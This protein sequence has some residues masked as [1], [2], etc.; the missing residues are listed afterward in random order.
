MAQAL[1]E[2]GAKSIALL[3]IREDLGNSTAAE[4]HKTTGLPIQFYAVDVTD[5]HSVAEAVSRAHK[6]LGAIDIV[7]NSAGIAE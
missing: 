3:D 6:D 7:V 1:A 4:L 5:E 2:A